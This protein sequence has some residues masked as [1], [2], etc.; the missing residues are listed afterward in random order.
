[1]WSFYGRASYIR[2][3]V[4]EEIMIVCGQ[5][6]SETALWSW[7]NEEWYEGSGTIYHTAGGKSIEVND[8]STRH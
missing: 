8:S 2:Q 6:L 4:I 7:W 3:P 1:M 5:P